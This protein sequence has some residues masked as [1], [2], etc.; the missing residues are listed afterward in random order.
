MIY[1]HTFAR[2]GISDID[3]AAVFKQLDK[4]GRGLEFWGFWA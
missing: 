4:N 1:I 3:V 2:P